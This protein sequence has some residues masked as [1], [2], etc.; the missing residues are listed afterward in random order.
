MTSKAWLLSQADY[1]QTLYR[2]DLQQAPVCRNVVPAHSNKKHVKEGMKSRRGDVARDTVH[3]LDHLPMP[4]W[5]D[6]SYQR[7]SIR[8]GR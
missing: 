3:P 6:F 8:L 7:Q 1:V 5:L 2:A 4:T